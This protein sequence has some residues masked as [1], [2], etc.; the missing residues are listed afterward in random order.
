MSKGKKF[1]RALLSIWQSGCSFS[2]GFPPPGKSH[3]LHLSGILKV[4]PTDADWQGSKA[5]DRV[6]LTVTVAG[7]ATDFFS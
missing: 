6:V 2:L 4:F 1:G 3:G 5:A 7:E